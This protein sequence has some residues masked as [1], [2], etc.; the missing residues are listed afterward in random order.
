MAKVLLVDTNVS[1]SPLYQYL[2]IAG[3]EVYV[4][5]GNPDDFL[6]KCAKN[7]IKLDY[8][9]TAALSEL[10]IRLEIDYLVPGCNDLS[11]KACAT[12][13]AGGRFPG[14]ET[15]NNNEVLNNKESFR[16]F[17]TK[18][19]VPVPKVYSEDDLGNIKF[20]VI[21]KP[22][23]AFSGRGITI[24]QENSRHLLVTAINEARKQSRSGYYLIEEYVTGQLHSHSAFIASGSIVSDMIVEEHCTANPFA[25]DTSRVLSDFPAHVLNIVRL[26]TQKMAQALQLKDGLVH[27]QFIQKDDSVWLIEPTRRCP[28]D[29]YS[30]LIEKT[31]DLNYSEN[32]VR[33]FL[34][35][36]FRFTSDAS[37]K[38][39]VIRHTITDPEGGH[40][41]TLRFNEDVE[42]S[43]YVA[44]CIS[45]DTFKPAPSGRVG[46]L[47]ASATDDQKF[48]KLYQNTINRNLY[49]LEPSSLQ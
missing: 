8:S 47:F 33:P 40:F 22:V 26:A 38:H 7:Y 48:Q 12:V 45:G 21:V 17:A 1:A 32:Y 18:H 20:P 30:R 25:V 2:R 41:W 4:T 10:I 11:Y 29:L 6:A 23:D 24:I 16:S 37:V 3:H 13:N 27:T 19:G 44:L 5:G 42:V 28:G 46:I 39:L 34:G 36:P 15:L 31:T 9:D 35:L 43:E 49:K 14:I